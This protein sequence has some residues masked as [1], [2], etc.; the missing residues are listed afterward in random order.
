MTCA[1]NE[2]V[3]EGGMIGYDGV[4]NLLLPEIQKK[5]SE[6]GG[7]GDIFIPSGFHDTCTSIL[8]IFQYVILGMKSAR[9]ATKSYST[10]VCSTR[11]SVQSSR[12]WEA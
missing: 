1:Q 11:S 10:Y 8:G 9:G 5:P 2:V 4:G 6:L 12:I 3:W 7:G